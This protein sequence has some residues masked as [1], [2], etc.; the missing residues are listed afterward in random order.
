MIK[1]FEEFTS[2]Y[3]IGDYVLVDTKRAEKN[4][5]L[6]YEDDNAYL[7]YKTLMRFRYAIDGK[8]GKIPA[9]IIEMEANYNYIAVQFVN[10][11]TYFFTPDEIVRKLE[12][13]E[14][15]KFEVEKSTLRY[16]L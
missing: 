7:E 16:N 8:I 6:A 2:D 4:I 10:G 11:R 12:S 9:K 14:I 15:E 1:I 13:K 3:K 5:R